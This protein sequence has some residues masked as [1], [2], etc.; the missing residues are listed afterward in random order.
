M[1]ILVT[2]HEGY[3]GAVLVPFLQVAGHDV[4]GLDNGLFRDCGF[5][6]PLTRVP[7]LYLDIRE[8]QQEHLRGLDAVIHLA[9]ISN[10][11]VG[12]LDPRC[13]YEVNH[14]ASVR[15][16]NL[17]KRAG[18][19]RFLFSSSCSLYGA[20]GEHYVD[21]TASLLPLTPY[22][23]S[24]VRVEQ[25]VTLLADADF[26]PT[27][28]RNATAYGMSPRL[29]ADLVVNNLAGF[30]TLQREVLLSSDG[31]AWRPLVHVE[32]IS[33]AF[34]A[35]VE[36]PRELVHNQA[37][38]IGHTGENYQIKEVA[39]IVQRVVPGSRVVFRQGAGTD[40]R[41]YRVDCGKFA[42]TFPGAVPCWTVR[43]GVEELHEAYQVYGL[44]RADFLGR[45]VRIAHIRQLMAEGRLDKDLRWTA[46]DSAAPAETAPACQVGP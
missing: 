20:A 25:D 43:W 24:K 22:G 23:D 39:E 27:F 38:N 37:F 42:R 7:S 6:R 17:A 8:V 21:E 1:R 9:G 2:G 4:V 30:A 19:P 36:A 28:L 18:V 45:L 46:I 15:L 12:D 29:R 35:V 11:P 32:D 31:T 33:R 3:I 26:S 34:L 16:A 10:D 14:Q 40:A 13:T 41:D 5:G 44:T